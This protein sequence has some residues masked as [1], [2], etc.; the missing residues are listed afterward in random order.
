MNTEQQQSWRDRNAWLKNE[1][2][3]LKSP[4]D[5][6]CKLYDCALTQLVTWRELAQYDG[7]EGTVNK[8]IESDPD[9][10]LGHVLNSGIQLI[11]SSLKPDPQLLT[12]LESL[13]TKRTN[14]GMALDKHELLHHQAVIELW[15]GNVKQACDLW[16]SVLIETPSDMMAIKFAHDSY[17][18][19]GLH[20]Q[21][22]DSLAR[23]IP[24][25][26]QS[27]PLYSYLHGM[28][29]F[30][31]VQSGWFDQGLKAAEKSLSLGPIDANATHAICHYYE[32]KCDPN[33]GLK[34]LEKHEAEW[35]KCNLYSM[36]HYWH[37]CN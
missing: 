8:M 27:Q 30:G 9:F 2:I 1:H 10:F 6:A 28:H 37:R 35:A 23:V 24:K 16:E 19:T 34:F 31:L 26:K 13:K 20:A 29:S 21:M 33:S 3:D 32:Y 15:N 7:L 17:F 14:S 11:G 12:T 18:Y 4:S 5:E 25:W 22:R 36:H